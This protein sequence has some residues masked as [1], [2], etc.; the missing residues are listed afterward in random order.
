MPHGANHPFHNSDGHIFR[1]D[2]ERDGRSLKLLDRDTPYY[3]RLNLHWFKRLQSL[4]DVPANREAGTAIA[5]CSSRADL[6]EIGFTTFLRIEELAREMNY[7]DVNDLV[8]HLIQGYRFLQRQ[9]A[10]PDWLSI[11]APHIALPPPAQPGKERGGE[12]G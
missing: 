3:V 6:I 10:A 2:G 4:L 8:T 9:T 11:D 1:Q 7:R 5:G 12:H